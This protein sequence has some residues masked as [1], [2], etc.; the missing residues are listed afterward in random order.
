MSQRR[1]TND[2]A[3]RRDVAGRSICLDSPSQRLDRRGVSFTKRLTAAAGTRNSALV[4]NK[5][6]TSPACPH[7]PEARAFLVE[8]GVDFIEFDVTTDFEALRLM[9]TMTGRTDVPTLIA[10]YHAVVGFD[11]DAWNDLLV[12]SSETQRCDPMALPPE[13]GPDPYDGVD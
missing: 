4:R 2:R 6:Y 13:I 3:R 1:A 12:H 10:G 9:L 7:C 8:K 11:E 5:L